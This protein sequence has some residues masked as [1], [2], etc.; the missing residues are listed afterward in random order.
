MQ[1][2][3]IHNEKYSKNKTKEKAV[4]RRKCFLSNDASVSIY[5]RI[6]SGEPDVETGC[7]YAKHTEKK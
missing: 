1:C 7:F 6:F 4:G 3:N 5:T 2:T